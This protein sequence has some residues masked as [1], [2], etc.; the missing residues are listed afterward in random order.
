MYGYAGASATATQLTPFS[1]PPQT[2]QPGGAADQSAAVVQATG[3]A[4]ANAQTAVSHL[5]SATPQALRAAG[6]PAAA[7]PAADPPSPVSSLTT[8][9]S[10]LNSSPL[11]NLA[12]NV[13]FVTKGLR[14]FND[15]ALSITLGLVA[16]ARTMNDTAVELEGPLFAELGSA[17]Q[18]LGAAGPAAGGSAVS[19]AVGNAGLVGALPVPPSWAVATPAIRLA[20][21]V[22]QGTSATAAAAAADS[23]GSL[24]GRMAL[25]GLAGSALGGAVPR[26]RAGTGARGEGRPASDKESKTPE[27]LKRVLAEL[28]QKPESV[29]HWHTDKAHLESLLDQLSKKP[30]V[31]A[32]HLSATNKPKPTPSKAPWG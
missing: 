20:A 15:T 26:A 23:A 9:L 32:V 2:T 21:T 25:A 1:T 28:S 29:Q 8:F 22:L 13:E 6:M 14:P 18:A 19:A 5:M 3:T 7:V 12:A 27:K 4:P 10:N 17:T 16:A 24:F 30:G 11:A 31:H